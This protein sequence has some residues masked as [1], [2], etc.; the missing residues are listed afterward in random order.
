[1]TP[2]ASAPLVGALLRRPFMAVRTQVIGSLREAGFD[3]LQPAHLAVFQFPGPVGRSP[4]ELAADASISKQAMNNLLAQLEAG[5]YLV[6][7]VNPANRRERL[8]ELTERGT[9]AMQV[10]RT[11]IGTLERRWATALGEGDYQELIGALVHLNEHIAIT[12]G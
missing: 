5:G 9:A 10:M 3:D 1:M 12:Q 7:T 4:S 6:R 2:S 11:S 8:I